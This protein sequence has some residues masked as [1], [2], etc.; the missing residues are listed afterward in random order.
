MADKEVFNDIDDLDSVPQPVE[1][2]NLA[3]ISDEQTMQ[4]MLAACDYLHEN[5]QLDDTTY[6]ALKSSLAAQ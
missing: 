3:A 5:G 2:V 1:E 6:E 4:I